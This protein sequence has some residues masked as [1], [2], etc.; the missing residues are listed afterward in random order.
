MFTFTCSHKQARPKQANLSKKASG[1]DAE[2]QCSGREWISR[3]TC[4]Y[5]EADEGN[6]KQVSSWAGKVRWW[7]WQER[8]LLPGRRE[9]LDLR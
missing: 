7:E 6:E 1:R 9:C 8:G 2:V 4:A 5:C 3:H